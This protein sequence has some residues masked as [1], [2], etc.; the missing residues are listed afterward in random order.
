MLSAGFEPTSSTGKQP[1]TYTLDGGATGTG[2]LL[3]QY[4]N[5]TT[6]KTFSICSGTIQASKRKIPL[7][8]SLVAYI[9]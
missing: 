4:N 8:V 7:A 3:Y 9:S 5:I 6:L 2:N 1:Q